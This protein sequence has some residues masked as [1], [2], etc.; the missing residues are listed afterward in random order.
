M[1][2]QCPDSSEP[3]ADGSAP[4]PS[5]VTRV[6]PD[7]VTVAGNVRIQESRYPAGFRID[8]H[9]HD[10]TSVSLVLEGELVERS[11]HGVHRAGPGSVVTKPAGTEHANRFGAAGARL[12]LLDVSRT[13]D[14]EERLSEHGWKWTDGGGPARALLRVLEAVR[15][16]PADLG[17]I[18]EETLEQLPSL[19]HGEGGVEEGPPPDWVR[20]VRRR[21]HRELR[22]PPRVRDLA[23]DADVHP[24]HLT[25]RFKGAYGVTITGY[26]RRLRAREAARLIASRRGSLA[27]IAYRVGFSDQS[28]F[29]RVFKEQ[30]GLTPGRFRDLL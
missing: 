17:L 9:W 7:A 20:E 12:L 22:E 5:A 30:M 28:H 21:L 15:A 27:E 26:V 10:R 11:E 14:T 24:T 2:T 19:L 1:S 29:C 16:R 4:G 13:G 18:V 25:R 6:E 8:R 23:A 3:P